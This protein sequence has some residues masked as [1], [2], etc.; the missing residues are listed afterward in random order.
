MTVKRPERRHIEQEEIK[1]LSYKALVPQRININTHLSG[2]C[3]NL[4]KTQ[5][6]RRGKK[7]PIKPHDTAG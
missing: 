3:G 6:S 4:G 2:G 5:G 7:D 1:I